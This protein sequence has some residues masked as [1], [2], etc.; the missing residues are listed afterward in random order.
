MKFLKNKKILEI[1]EGNPKDAE[2]ILAVLK[3]VGSESDNLIID[4]NGVQLT[5]EQEEE[6]L[7]KNQK[8]ITNKNF[9]GKVDGKVVCTAGIQGNARKRVEHNVTLGI[10]ILKD[11]W[12][13][14]IGGHMMNHILNYC[15]TT[16][17]IKNVVLEVREDN[18]HAIH[19]Y[20]K[21]GFKKIGVFTDKVK[22]DDKYYN[23]IIMEILLNK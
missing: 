23:E 7:K 2:E 16:K 10:S 18:V 1:S 13:I 4:S 5:V 22:I 11:Y 6:Y 21:L 12:N 8:S 9:I 19:L 14:G 3:Q 20:E 15:R 17:L